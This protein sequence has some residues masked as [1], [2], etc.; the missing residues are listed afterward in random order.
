[1][2]GRL[3]N[4]LL[5]TQLLVSLAAFLLSIETRILLSLEPVCIPENLFISF[6]T[7]S[8]YHL[9]YLKTKQGRYG[10]FYLIP[11]GFACLWYFFKLQAT[12][13]WLSF[14]LILAAG[15]YIMP[16]FIPHPRLLRRTAFKSI[17]LAVIW[18]MATWTIP[19]QG[20]HLSEGGVVVMG[21]RLAL[22]VFLIFIFNTEGRVHPLKLVF[23]LL[24][25]IPLFFLF[26]QSW[27]AYHKIGPTYGFVSLM[28]CLLAFGVFRYFIK[29]QRGSIQYL[30]LADGLMVLHSIFVLIAWN[31]GNIQQ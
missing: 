16:R 21:F 23:I 29:K 17:L 2:P 24:P 12:S 31:Y 26:V 13:Q 8:A 25:S 28:T 20:I 7:L 9:Y 27:M 19:A 30:V 10:L 1:M 22:I 4:F 14:F 11:A 18:F 15:L 3:L 6:A 5:S